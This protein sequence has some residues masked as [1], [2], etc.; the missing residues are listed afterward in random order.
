MWGDITI[1]HVLIYIEKKAELLRPKSNRNRLRQ[2]FAF[3]ER[4][5]TDKF[6]DIKDVE[7]GKMSAKEFK[8]KWGISKHKLMEQN[9]KTIIIDKDRIYVSSSNQ[10]KWLCPICLATN[11]LNKRC[12]NCGYN[13]KDKD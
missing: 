4:D 11:L 9:K 3:L 7:K 2:Y 12:V 10:D 6:W 5:E 13:D 1:N 8:E